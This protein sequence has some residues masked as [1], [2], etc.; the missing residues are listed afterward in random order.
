MT[1][2]RLRLVYRN[3]RGFTLIELVI[4]IAIAGVIASAVM[5]TIFQVFD[6]NVRSSAHMTAVKQVESAV[7]WMSRDIRMAQD[8][9]TDGGGDF[10]VKL[11]WV[12]WD[13]PIENVVIYKL[14][15]DGNLIRSHSVGDDE[16]ET[17]VAQ[18]IDSDSVVSR[19]QEVDRVVTL[20]I[21]A[22][23]T[24][25]RPSSETRVVEVVQRPTAS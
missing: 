15:D 17:I 16:T 11:T 20:E 19:D 9:D 21:T 6:M 4:V 7:H 14:Q 18:H 22:T 8:I 1:G 23:V 12:E 5:M 2:R 24:G 13:P 25:F 10:L 3:Q